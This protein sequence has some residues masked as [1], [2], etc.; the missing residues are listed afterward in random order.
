MSTT[1]NFLAS[2]YMKP[3]NLKKEEEK[4]E[5]EQRRRRKQIGAIPG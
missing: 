5:Q 4:E 2:P 1:R 3:W